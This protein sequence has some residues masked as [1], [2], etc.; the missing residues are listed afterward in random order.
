MKKI[1]YLF[2]LL[3]TS[4]TINAEIIEV[5]NFNEIEKIV[6]PLNKSD[7][8]LLD[9]DYTLIEPSHP[10]LQMSVIKQNKKL[11]RE[12]IARYSAEENQIIP[13]LMVTHVQ[14]QLT[15][16][17][18]PHFLMRLHQQEIPT[19]G[20]TALDTCSLPEL[21]YIPAWRSKDLAKHHLIFNPATFADN[22]YDFTDFPSFRG[23]YPTFHDGILYCNVICSKGTILKSFLEQAHSKPSKIIFIDDSLDN[24]QSVEKELHTLGISFLGIHYKVKASSTNISEKDWREVWDMINDRM[25]TLNLTETNYTT[26]NTKE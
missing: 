17:H 8:V 2:L 6:N 26:P 22:N 19:L 12:E 3:I 21:G 7:L 23:S 25:K 15:D 5:N 4:Q 9:I 24:L 1:I 14:S 13:L 11:F 16:P 10:A 18:V 20:F